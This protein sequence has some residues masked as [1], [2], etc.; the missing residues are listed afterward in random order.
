MVSNLFV[1]SITFHGG[2]SAIAYPW[3]SYNHIRS[4]DLDSYYVANEAPDH[5]ALDSLGRAML[6]AAGENIL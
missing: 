1:T 4:N 3:G 5:K 6:E 2:T